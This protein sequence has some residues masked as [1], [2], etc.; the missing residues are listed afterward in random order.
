VRLYTW[1][2]LGLADEA[3]SDAMPDAAGGEGGHG[4]AKPD[5]VIHR[6]ISNSF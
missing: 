1:A 4:P 2:R 3:G 6:Y 5:G